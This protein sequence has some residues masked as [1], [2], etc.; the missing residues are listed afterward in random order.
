MTQTP[1]ADRESAFNHFAPLVAGIPESD[2]EP[3]HYDAEILR[4]NAQR[5]L[6]A[7]D[8]ILDATA[9]KMGNVNVDEIRDL[10]TIGL[11]LAFADARVF[12]AASAQEIKIT[13]ARQRPKR[14]LAI[15]QLV[16]LNEMGLIKDPAKVEAILPGKGP[17]DEAR[18]GV[19]CV[20]V[21]RANAAEVMGK[22]PF[23]DA[24]LAELAADSNWLLEQLQISGAKVDKQP[25]SAD[26]L[27]RDQLF[28]EIVRRHGQGKK[29]AVERWGWKRVDE[30]Y[31][32]LF[33]R[34]V[35]APAAAAAPAVVAA[36]AAVKPEK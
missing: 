32:S 7:L 34:V 19:A 5:A 20:S 13:Q 16:I 17:V 25:K 9:Q 21:F 2:L 18:D 30:H 15:A 35:T 3:W 6:D 8:P 29:V 24:W 31:P 1:S 14:K 11:A 23:D 33:A 26:S 27:V 22:H 4:V 36:P 12:L 10:P 28:T